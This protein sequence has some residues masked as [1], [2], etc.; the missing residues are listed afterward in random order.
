MVSSIYFAS[1]ETVRFCTLVDK[2]LSCLDIALGKMRVY[3]I[4]RVYRTKQKKYL[5]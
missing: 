3:S 5:E 2:Y 4:S 1:F